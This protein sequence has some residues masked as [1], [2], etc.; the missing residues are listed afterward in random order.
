MIDG[1][2]PTI[3]V[4]L[5]AVNQSLDTCQPTK[6]SQNMSEQAGACSTAEGRYLECVLSPSFTLTAVNQIQYASNK[7]FYL[8]NSL[9]NTGPEIHHSRYFKQ[10]FPTGNNQKA[11][12]HPQQFVD[13]VSRDHMVKLRALIGLSCGCSIEQTHRNSQGGISCRK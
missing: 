8:S 11:R 10:F 2:F 6:T 5:A 1:E 12:C 13:K 7:D 9:Q 4:T 3:D